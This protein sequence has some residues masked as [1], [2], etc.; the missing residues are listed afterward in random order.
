MRGVEL[1]PTNSSSS[2]GNKQVNKIGKSCE[3][4]DRQRGDNGTP[5]DFGPS[6]PGGDPNGIA[7]QK[8]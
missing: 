1:L 7:R 4:G 6:G 8:V 2:G 5:A 3:S